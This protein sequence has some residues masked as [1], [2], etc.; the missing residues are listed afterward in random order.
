MDCNVVQEE[1]QRQ[2]IYRLVVCDA[3]EETPAA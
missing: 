3:G 2:A 1:E